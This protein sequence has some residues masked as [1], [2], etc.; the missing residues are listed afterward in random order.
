MDIYLLFDTDALACTKTMNHL[1]FTHLRPYLILIVV[2]LV[3]GCVGNSNITS[4]AV[5]TDILTPIASLPSTVEALPVPNPTVTPMV[6]GSAWGVMDNWSPANQVRAVLIDQSGNLWTGGSTGVTYWDLKTNMS[7][8]YVIR[9]DPERTNVVALS[10]T[11]DGSIWA[12]TDGNG[13]ARFDGTSWQS[14]TTHNGLPGNY[15]KDQT[16]K[17]NGELWLV[18]KEKE[19][20][21]EP[22]QKIH[23][24][25]FDGKTWLDDFDA[26]SFTWLV[27]SPNGSLIT[28]LASSTYNPPNSNL[29]IYDGN[30]WTSLVFNEQENNPLR[31]TGITAIAVAPDEAIWVATWD[32]VFRYE[33]QRWVK[34]SSPLEGGDLPNVSSI[35][36]S[37]DGTAWFGFSYGASDHNSQCGERY[38]ATEEQGVYRYDGKTWTHFTTEDGLI[39]NKICAITIDANNNVWFGSFDKGVSR[40]DGTTWTSYVIP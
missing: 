22:Y 28:G 33:N 24:G 21:S 6:I 35:A 30:T 40:F 14:F 10:Q 34:I 8:I 2:T 26:P 29:W 9:S 39:D 19:Y 31:G 25:H 20:D 36:V 7:T 23:L 1:R 15:I 16:V 17:P 18:V 4:T 12:G 3:T 5:S 27:S 38:D 32:S 37:V 11:P 13:L